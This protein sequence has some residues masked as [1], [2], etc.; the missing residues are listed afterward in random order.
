MSKVTAAKLERFLEF[1][2]KGDYSG[3]CAATAVYGHTGS[4]LKKYF[5]YH[6]PL[7]CL[8]RMEENKSPTERD[9]WWPNGDKEPRIKFL[10]SHIKA[11]KMNPIS[12]WFYYIYLHVTL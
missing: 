7:S 3:L 1:F 4:K 9:Y 6:I 8:R 10:E 12:R 2:E 5:F 11:L